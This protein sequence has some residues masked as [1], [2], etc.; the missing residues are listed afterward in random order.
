M[1]CNS[2]NTNPCCCP[3]YIGSAYVPG[4]Q[5]PMGAQGVQ[6]DTGPI[7]PTGPTGYTGPI[8]LQG[9]TGD[10]GYTGYTGSQ[11]PAG[12]GGRETYGFIVDSQQFPVSDGQPPLFTPL[13]PSIFPGQYPTPADVNV[14]YNG[15]TPAT[16]SNMLVEM[17]PTGINNLQG[18]VSLDFCINGVP[19]LPS[20]IITPAD[21]PGAFLVDNVGST[22][23]NPGDQFCIQQT[24]LGG[25][26]GGFTYVRQ[27]SVIFTY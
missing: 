5:G 6:G 23:I 4:P 11:G 1:S 19:V 27:I 24:D 25:P 21:I 7:G 18:N 17:D 26:G 14:Y 15:L 13:W 20:V 12:G 8:G 22:V 2:C 16:V 3:P 10:T 9:P